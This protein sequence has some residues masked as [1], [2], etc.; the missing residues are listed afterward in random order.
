MSVATQ[1]IPKVTWLQ[2]LKRRP[3]IVLVPVVFVLVI[4]TWEWL[5]RAFNVSE[6]VLPA[7]S[8]ICTALYRGFQSGLF[9]QG[10]KA[11]LTAI[12]G[13][14]AIAAVLALALGTLISQIR[15]LEVTFYPYIVAFQTVPKVA[16]APLIVMWVG[17]G[18]ESKIAIAAAVSFF[19]MLVNDIVGLKATDPEKIDLM[20]SLNASRLKI[21]YMVQLPEALPY[22]F[23]GLNIG[24]VLAV[25]GAIVG[26][27]VGAKQ[28][29]GYLIM[30]M[31][32]NLDIAG[33][34]AVLVILAVLGIILN[35]VVVAARRR[36]IFWRRDNLDVA[37]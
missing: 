9:W 24:I 25:L 16:I 18:I 4:A 5:V 33:V 26:E 31:N 15:I 19:P 27:F 7:P 11:T 6:F 36:L 23:A 17:F 35:F 14:Y 20:R 34:F 8:V 21:F 2:K 30:Q 13:G 29:L 1:K 3:E 12:L 37:G 32:Y 22:I 28:G 10:L